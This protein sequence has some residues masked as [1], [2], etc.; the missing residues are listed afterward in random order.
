M[1][2]YTSRRAS[3]SL[4]ESHALRQVPCELLLLSGT[5]VVNEAM[6]TGESTPQLKE[7]I[8]HEDMEKTFDMKRDGKVHVL[9]GGTRLV[10]HSPDKDG[11]HS[12]SRTSRATPHVPLNAHALDSHTWGARCNTSQVVR[13]CSPLMLPLAPIKSPNNGCLGIVLRTGFETA[14]GKL[15]RTILF[16]TQRVTANTLETFFFILFL[17]CFAVAA[18]AYVLKHVRMP[19]RTHARF[20][21]DNGYITPVHNTMMLDR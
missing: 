19:T 6:L 3:L 1:R 21:A 17:L 18:S 13:L 8:A 12:Q 5:C 4:H 14:Q 20:R 16:S 9:F 2:A 15:M 7:S 10:Q 11:T